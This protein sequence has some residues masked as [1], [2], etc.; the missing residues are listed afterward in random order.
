MIFGAM[1]SWSFEFQIMLCD[2]KTEETQQQFRSMI[3]QQIADNNPRRLKG[4]LDDPGN[5]PAPLQLCQQLLEDIKRFKGQLV[6]VRVL[7]NRCL[8]QRHWDEISILLGIDVRPDAGASLRKMLKLPFT[9][10]LLE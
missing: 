8:R 10:E 1:D 7:C 9:P 6:L 5:L 4:T 2:R 3:K